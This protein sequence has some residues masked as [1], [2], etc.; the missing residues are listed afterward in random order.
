MSVSR[1]QFYNQVA[2]NIGRWDSAAESKADWK[3]CHAQ[4][5]SNSSSSWGGTESFKTCILTNGKQSITG[6]IYSFH[7]TSA[8]LLVYIVVNTGFTHN[9]SGPWMTT[10]VT[11]NGR[12]RRCA[13]W[14]FKAHANQT[15]WF[16]LS[17]ICSSISHLLLFLPQV[18]ICLFL[19][20]WKKTVKYIEQFPNALALRNIKCWNDIVISVIAVSHKRPKQNVLTCLAART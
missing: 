5:M 20:M 9:S 17:F 2:Q 13:P 10:V 15:Q 14:W 6:D 16:Y 1:Q 19:F 4:T 11:N 3:Q 12:G 7:S 8:V 18:A